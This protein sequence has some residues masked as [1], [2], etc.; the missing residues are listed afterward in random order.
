MDAEA[1]FIHPLHQALWPLIPC[2]RTPEARP[3]EEAEPQTLGFPSP[4]SSVIPRKH[5]S[6]QDAGNGSKERHEVP[7]TP[8]NA[9]ED[10]AGY[11][12]VQLI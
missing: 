6:S 1:E 7:K 3:A 5:L 12:K 11:I 4:S 2:W 9:F 8:G 10:T